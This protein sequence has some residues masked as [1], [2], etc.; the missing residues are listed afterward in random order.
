[1]RALTSPQKMGMESCN[2]MMA[3]LKWL[4]MI[5]VAH[6]TKTIGEST[7]RSSATNSMEEKMIVN[8]QREVKLVNCCN[9][10]YAEDEL[11]NAALWYSDKPI[12]STKKIVLRRNYPSICIYDKKIGIHRLL[13]MYWLQGEIPDG[14]V[15]HHINENKLDARKKNLALVPFTTHQHYHNAGKTL[16]VQHREKISQANYRRWERVRKDSIHDGE[17][18]QREEG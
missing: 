8:E 16:T 13:M 4:E 18:G 6:S 2:G 9:A 1:M 10:I 12:C 14:Y 17:G 11:I 15:V 7:L 5:F 3:R